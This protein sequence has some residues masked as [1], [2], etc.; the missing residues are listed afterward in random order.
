MMG[1][2][3]KTKGD[4]RLFMNMSIMNVSEHHGRYD[5]SSHV[6]ID[7]SFCTH[8]ISQGYSH[9]KPLHVSDVV[10]HCRLQTLDSQHDLVE[11]VLQGS[12]KRS[13]NVP[14]GFVSLPQSYT[15]TGQS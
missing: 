11:T 13:G 2:L 7:V 3:E 4:L 1:I 12:L 5:V 9:C 8:R 15:T 10:L 14:S 6:T